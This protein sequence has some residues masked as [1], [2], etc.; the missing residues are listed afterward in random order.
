MAKRRA[1]EKLTDAKELPVLSPDGEAPDF[2]VF[3][4]APV[5]IPETKPEVVPPKPVAEKK[6]KKDPNAVTLRVF[7]SVAGAKQDQL[8]GFKHFATKQDLGPMTVKEWRQKYQDFMN[9]PV[10]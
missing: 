1:K 5:E 9:R 8:A 10:Y 6:P 2:M 7:L 3:D 4:E